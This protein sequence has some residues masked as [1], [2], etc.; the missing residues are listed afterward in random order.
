M[1]KVLFLL[2]SFLFLWSCEQDDFIAEMP[3]AEENTVQ[4][5]AESSIADFNPTDEL[6][7]AEIPINIVNILTSKYLAVDDSRRAVLSNTVND[8]TQWYCYKQWIKYGGTLS[9]IG[10]YMVPLLTRNTLNGAD[11][12][13][14]GGAIPPAEFGC[15]FSYNSSANNY[16]IDGYPM[17]PLPDPLNTASLKPENANSNT[18]IFDKNKSDLSYW[19]ICP[20]GEYELVDI[21]YVRTTVDD[22]EL[23]SATQVS[24]N[25]NNFGELTQSFNVDLSYDWSQG[26]KYSK[27]EGVTTTITSGLNIGLPNLVGQDSSVGFNETISSQS[28]KS[29]TFGEDITE[30]VHVGL[31]ANISVPPHSVYRAVCVSY[32]HGGTLTYVATLKNLINGKNFRVKGKWEGDAFVHNEISI[33][34]V[35]DGRNVLVDRYNVE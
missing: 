16:T 9:G 18:L 29:H 4:T 27:T 2:S 24:T 25:V 22:F 21:E 13:Y 28:I 8:K 6:Y 5:R 1:R 31:T 32:I 14:V 35:T 11:Y 17:N 19:Q 7:D 30:T 23:N 15:Y 12:P 34:D 33:Y 3:I 20:V 26:S 10:G